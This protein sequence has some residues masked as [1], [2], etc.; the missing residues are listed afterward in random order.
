MGIDIGENAAHGDDVQASAAGRGR[1]RDAGAVGVIRG[2]R[3]RLGGGAGAERQAGMRRMVRSG[4]LVAALVGAA[5]CSRALAPATDAATMPAQAVTA[6]EA[7][8]ASPAA[9]TTASPPAESAA[10]T[11]TGVSVKQWLAAT[12]P[13]TVNL[14][15]GRP[16]LVKVF[17]FW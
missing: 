2:L 11:P 12:D 4:L 8:A 7:A 15:A 16:Q 13:T 6:T 9:A 17:A 1:G 5:A 3:A 10:P 14:A